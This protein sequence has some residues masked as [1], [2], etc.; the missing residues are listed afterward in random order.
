M[1][2]WPAVGAVDLTPVH[3]TECSLFGVR[4]FLYQMWTMPSTEMF[5]CTVPA[6]C[7]CFYMMWCQN[8]GPNLYEEWTEH[9]IIESLWVYTTSVFAV[10]RVLD[11]SEVDVLK[12]E[13]SCRLTAS[14]DPPGCS[15]K[16]PPPT[17]AFEHTHTLMNKELISLEVMYYLP[18]NTHGNLISTPEGHTGLNLW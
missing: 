1:K 11:Q 13:A 10:S 3:Y 12:Q 14:L 8:S 6:V 2:L 16:P 17:Q 5:S 15:A 4:V 18:N 9:R 7:M